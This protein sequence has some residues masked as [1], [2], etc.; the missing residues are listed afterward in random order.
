[1]LA[2]D[3]AGYPLHRLCEVWGFADALPYRSRVGSTNATFWRW[4]R[5]PAPVACPRVPPA[6]T[7]SSAGDRSQCGARPHLAHKAGAPS[8]RTVPASAARSPARQSKTDNPRNRTPAQSARSPFYPGVGPCADPWEKIM[9][10]GLSMAT[11][12]VCAYVTSR[13]LCLIDPW[14]SHMLPDAETNGNERPVT[15]SKWV[16]NFGVG[17]SSSFAARGP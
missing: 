5:T 7:R 14:A 16:I 9:G 13:A 11:G 17:E 8:L 3:I 6:P 15:G 4:L 1:M 2:Y 10:S 12:V